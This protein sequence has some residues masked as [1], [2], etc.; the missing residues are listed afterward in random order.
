MCGKHA[1]SNSAQEC[2]SCKKKYERRTE[3]KS[4][5]MRGRVYKKCSKC[6]QMA[7]SNRQTLCHNDECKHVFEKSQKTNKKKVSKKRKK[8]GSNPIAKKSRLADELFF[9]PNLFN[10]DETIHN[11]TANV[12]TSENE[13]LFDGLEDKNDFENFVGPARD[14]L[15]PFDRKCLSA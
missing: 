4:N 2:W 12:Q 9:D 7:K 14:H 1:K 11:A 3:K 6:G 5:D 15:G 8:S 13:S 10:F